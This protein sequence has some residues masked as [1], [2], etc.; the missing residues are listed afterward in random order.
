[1]KQMKSTYRKKYHTNQNGFM[2]QHTRIVSLTPDAIMD[3]R[4]ENTS[5]RYFLAYVKCYRSPQNSGRAY[6]VT[7]Q[8]SEISVG[9]SQLLRRAANANHVAQQ[10]LPVKGRGQEW[11][12]GMKVRPQTP[13]SL[14]QKKTRTVNLV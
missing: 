5:S 11:H 9:G 10:L 12:S 3:E 1:M 7:K 6:S 13:P 2:R 4:V 14:T 8:P